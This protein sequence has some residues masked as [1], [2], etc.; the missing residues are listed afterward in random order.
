MPLAEISS[1]IEQSKGAAAMAE[2]KLWDALQ[3]S[4]EKIPADLQHDLATIAGCL[5]AIGRQYEAFLQL[6]EGCG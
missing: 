5:G 4:P 6:I 1:L 2:M 3:L